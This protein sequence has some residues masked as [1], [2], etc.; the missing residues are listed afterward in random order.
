MDCPRP[1]S[2][3]IVVHY[4]QAWGTQPRSYVLQEG[5]ELVEL[6]TGG[7]GWVLSEGEWMEVLPGTLLWHVEGD[8]TIGRS[9]PEAPYSCLAVRMMS[10]LRGKRRVPRISYWHDL[11]AAA[12][13]TERAIRLF[14]DDGFDNLVL[15][16]Y[17]FSNLR[18]EALLYHHQRELA[19]VAEPLR[20]VRSIIESRYGEALKVSELARA[21]GWSVAHLHDQFRLVYGSSPRQ[22]LLERRLNAGRELLV[23]SGGSVKEIAAATGFTHSSAFCCAFRK[24]FGVTPKAYRDAYYYGR[25]S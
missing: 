4:H 9:D 14:L 12:A 5:V 13:L 17:L 16:D 2:L 18:L 23:G 8:E 20:I 24:A 1:H 21:A 11:G 3:E 7:R 25:A 10:A 6:V 15:L 19:G 22:V